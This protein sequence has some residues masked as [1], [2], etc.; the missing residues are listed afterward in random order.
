M[1]PL[2]HLIATQP[3]LLGEHAQA[4]AELVSAEVGKASAAWTRKATLGA[5]ALCCGSIAVVLAGVSLLLCAVVPG[6]QMPA[7][8]ALWAVPLVPALAAAGCVLAARGN[9]GTGSFAVL[10]EQMKADIAMLREVSAQ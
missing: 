9:G 5:G 6:A 4:Y 1:H 3:H 7:P 2:L 8:W 10:R